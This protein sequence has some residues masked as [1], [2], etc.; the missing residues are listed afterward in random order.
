MQHASCIIQLCIVS[1]LKQA[2]ESRQATPVVKVIPGAIRPFVVRYEAWVVVLAYMMMR[3]PLR[4]AHCRHLLRKR[5]TS[6]GDH[7]DV[8][9]LL[10]RPIRQLRHRPPNEAPP[11]A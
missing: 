3:M 1:R 4:H 9:V 11:V 6:L 8:T 10:Q 5:R 7:R 2:H